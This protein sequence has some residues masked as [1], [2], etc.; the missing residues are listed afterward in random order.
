MHTH[1]RTHTG[2]TSLSGNLASAQSLDRPKLSAPLAHYF[3]RPS[4][5]HVSGSNSIMGGGGAGVYGAGVLFTW[6]GM[7]G[8]VEPKD[9]R[10][11]VAQQQQQ[12]QHM[13]QQT[14]IHCVTRHAPRLPQWGIGSKGNELLLTLCRLQDPPP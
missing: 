7:Y 2:M 12:E 6:G 1:T 4:P 13:E 5:P 9:V 11:A 3:N 10:D 14:D 8:W